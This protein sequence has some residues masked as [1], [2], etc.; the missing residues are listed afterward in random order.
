MSERPKLPKSVSVIIDWG[1]GVLST[2]GLED[3]EDFE[4][5]RTNELVEE[6]MEPD[7]SRR[8]R[9]TGRESVSLRTK[10]RTP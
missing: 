9:W 7:G 10:G 1:E 3:L 8:W 6:D 5:V 4:M 2:V